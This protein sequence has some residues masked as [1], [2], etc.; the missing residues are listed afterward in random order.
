MLM[1]HFEPSWCQKIFW[2]CKTEW[3][4]LSLWVRRGPHLNPIVFT[5]FFKPLFHDILANLHH[6]KSSRR[7]WYLWKNPSKNECGAYSWRAHGRGSSWSHQLTV[8][9]G[10]DQLS[11]LAG[12]DGA[13]Q[14]E[15]HT[16]CWQQHEECDLWQRGRKRTTWCQKCCSLPTSVQRTHL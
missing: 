10:V 6:R 3:V 7:H 2:Q 4:L 14:V 11:V 9:Q 16:H 12:E 5:S 13:R 15:H 8:F 1:G